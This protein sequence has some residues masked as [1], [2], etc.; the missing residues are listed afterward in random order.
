VNSKRNVR[1]GVGR[2]IKELSNGRAVVPVSL[3]SSHRGQ[4]LEVIAAGVSCD[5]PWSFQLS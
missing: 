1:S 2:E 3:K 4:I 5:Q